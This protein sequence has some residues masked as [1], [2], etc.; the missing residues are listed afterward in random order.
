MERYKGNA[1]GIIL[2]GHGISPYEKNEGEH[3]KSSGEGAVDGRSLLYKQ[4]SDY[5]GFDIDFR[6]DINVDELKDFD[7]III[8]GFPK[9]NIIK[10]LWESVINTPK[11]IKI[12]GVSSDIHSDDYCNWEHQITV[13]NKK[14]E[15][16]RKAL[17]RSD[18]TITS[19]Y[20]ALGEIYPEY[21]DQMIWSP[22]FF[23]PHERY[24]NL[25][26]NE[27]P[28]MKCLFTGAVGE[29][30][31][32][33]LHI[34]RNMEQAE[35]NIVKESAWFDGYAKMLNKYFCC[36]GP[37]PFFNSTLT[38]MFE[39]TAAGSLLLTDTTKDLTNLG[40]KP[41]VHYIPITEANVFK[42]VNMVLKNPNDYNDIRR[43]GM[44]FSRENFSINNKL[45]LMIE[46]IE[47][48]LEDKKQKNDSFSKT[49]L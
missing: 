35:G 11:N 1:K 10:L 44:I 23:G 15:W 12:V 33:R 13:E 32:L 43:N 6:F 34:Y 19:M 14:K 36:L 38:K 25:P 9:R 27:N 4:L 49:V 28:V 39:I 37:S 26:F 5:F 20:D 3:I 17:N 7:V 45:E 29:A 42:Q 22:S 47:N 46:V 30:Y 24:V 18:V 41:N 40:F 2:A 48:V 21:K 16:F 8:Q 31:P